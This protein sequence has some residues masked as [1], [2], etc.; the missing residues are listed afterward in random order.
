MLFAYSFIHSHSSENGINYLDYAALNKEK[1]C[2]I[3]GSHGSEYEVQSLL[4]C[5]AMF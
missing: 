4:G 2:E 3:S 1:P 5:T